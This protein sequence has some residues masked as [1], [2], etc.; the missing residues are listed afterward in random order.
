LPELSKSRPRSKPRN[1]LSRREQWRLLFVVMSLGLVIVLM[2]EAGKP[3][4]YRWLWP[5]APEEGD[6]APAPKPPSDAPPI[7][8][9]IA[10][11][12]PLEQ[13]AGTFYSPAPVDLE[14]EEDT[15]GEYFGGV[16]P[17][18]LEAVHDDTTFRNDERHA[19][20]NLF[21]VLQ[22]TD[23]RKLEKASLGRVTYFQLFEQTNEYRGKLV[24]IRGRVH[25]A[26]SLRAPKN[27]V[28]IEEYY[29]LWVQ[30]DDAPDY[31]I[32]VY[33]LGLPEGFPTGMKVLEGVQITGFYF[34]RWAYKA[35]ETLRTAPTLAAK[36]VRRIK[37]PPQEETS[38]GPGS[39]V[40]VVVVAAMFAVFAAAYVYMRTRFDTA[41]QPETAPR[42]EALS[43][44]ELGPN[45]DQPPDPP[46]E[47]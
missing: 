45:A 34:K 12:P 24:T 27:D 37:T 36:S 32:V 15:S 4:N 10:P 8:D 11:K 14:A 47:K 46:A 43:E 28:G 30:P 17:K 38:L 23:E 1:Y 41:A 39:V 2:M 21:D 6:S 19:W 26:L 13:S 29:Q 44:I 18:L 16:K 22:K 40:L 5:T 33:C 42:L 25:R 7:D 3:E 35:P 31:P 9:R 20:F